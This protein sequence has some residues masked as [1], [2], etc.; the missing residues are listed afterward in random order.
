MFVESE[1]L[2][3]VV[4]APFTFATEHELMSVAT[5]LLCPDMLLLPRLAYPLR[6]EGGNERCGG[7]FGGGGG[8]AE[9]ADITHEPASSGGGGGGGGASAAA[10][11]S[12]L[13]YYDERPKETLE[14]V[15]WEVTREPRSW[16]NLGVT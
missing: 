11:T 16:R 13:G 9:T 6:P 10:K 8:V 12:G 7:G 1:A 2:F 14:M 5:T 15:K 4:P 3:V